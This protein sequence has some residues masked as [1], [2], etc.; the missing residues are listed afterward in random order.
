M[1]RI[2]KKEYGPNSSDFKKK[3]KK[4]R[5]QVFVL[6]SSRWPKI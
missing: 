5:C 6:G 1:E 2:L 4:K 3:E